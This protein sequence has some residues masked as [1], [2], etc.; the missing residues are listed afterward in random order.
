[1]LKAFRFR[2]VLKVLW[3]DRQ[4]GVRNLVSRNYKHVLLHDTARAFYTEITRHL[5]KISIARQRVAI[6]MQSQRPTFRFKFTFS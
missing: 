1:M 3:A 6:C 5:G 2:Y 4:T